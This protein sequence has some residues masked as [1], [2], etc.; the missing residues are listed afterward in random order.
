MSDPEALSLVEFASIAEGTR[1]VDALV[2][3]AP[4]EVVRVGTLQPGKLAVLFIGDVASVAASH[5]E[6][7]RVGSASLIDDVML[8][9][10][11]AQ[12]YRAT[13]GEIGDFGGD[14]LGVLET[15]S[16]S[17]TIVGADAAIKGALVR[18]VSIR[19]GDGLGG[20]G[21]CHV[22]GDRHDVDAAMDIASARAAGRGRSVSVSVT[23]RLSPELRAQLERGT[24][25]W[26]EGRG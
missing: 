6:A 23:S 15:S 18:V 25:F 20:K 22:V 8:P 2:K 1:A 5:G 26:S 12:V 14:T 7:L 13:L 10:V 24:R 4:V 21:L 17:A 19:L 11:D 16:L 9:H 3:K